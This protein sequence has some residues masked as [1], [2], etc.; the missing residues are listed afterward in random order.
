LVLLAGGGGIDAFGEFKSGRESIGPIK[1]DS[2][3]ILS[4]GVRV[5]M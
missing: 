4:P 3:V 2:S 1:A 5:L